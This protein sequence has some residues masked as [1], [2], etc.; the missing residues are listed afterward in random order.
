M[1]IAIVDVGSNNI[2]LEIFEVAADGHSHLVFSE[3]FQARLGADVFLTRRLRAENT[4]I[5]IAA[6]KQ[7]RRITQEFKCRN[8]VAVA[9]AAL[10]E[11]DS[12]DFIERVRREAQ[13]NVSIISGLEEARLVYS[14]VRAHTSLGQGNF[15]IND[16]GGGSTEILVC[17]DN[18]IHF[19]ESLRLGTVRL[20][21]MFDIEAKDLVKLVEK[22][23]QRSVEPYLD[24]IRRFNPE[25][26]LCTGGT[27]RTILEILREM[28]VS[29]R[30][31]LRL[32]MVETKD[33]A[34]V[35]DHLSQMS[36]KELARIKSI[37][38]GR[39]DIILPGAALLLGLLRHTRMNRFMVSPNGLRDGAL[40]DYV[41]NKV[42]KNVYL[43]SQTQFR[44]TGL[45]TIVDKYKMDRG[46][47]EHVAELSVQLFD[48]FADLH[49]LPPETRDLLKAAAML[50]DI[51]KFIDYSQ[52]HKH[53]LYILSNMNL[54]GYDNDE[55]DIIAHTARYH[56]KSNPKA[57]H[58]EFQRLSGRKQDIV[59]K[60]SVLLR[61]ADSLDR[62]YAS[63]ITGLRARKLGERSW[64]LG[65][66]SAVESQLERWAFQRKKDQFEKVF[67]ATLELE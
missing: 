59:T 44:E 10:R 64:Q 11:C 35:V 25:A 40:A 5:A 39:R 27:A 18:D 8:T 50:H 61:I 46:H 23:V 30:E 51:G 9:T 24:D 6:L 55:R 41:Y 36:R 3:K 29:L 32:P 65:F 2:K 26:A 13:I 28:G 37:D 19:V 57:S 54:P 47:S 53:A 43:R 66:D 48:L 67:G 16:I 56:R 52:H 4:E 63:A 14:G 17:N 45:T 42:N 12:T 7:I 15:L 20:R 38:E 33:F 31:Q 49:R 34:E 60:L 1:N 21:D 62:S 58:V 22:Y